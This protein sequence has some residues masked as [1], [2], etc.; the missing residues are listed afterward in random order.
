MKKKQ[1]ITKDTITEGF[2]ISLALV[3]FIPVFFFLFTILL[4]S[5]KTYFNYFI[6]TGNIICFVSGI[7]KVIWKLIV[8]LKKKNVWWMFQQ[9]RI[10]LPIGF[11]LIM[12]GLIFGWKHFSN[13]FYNASFY[14]R[15]FFTLWIIGMSLMSFFAV[16]LDPADPKANWIEQITNSIAQ[17]FLCLA[18]YFL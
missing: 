9:M 3:D 5:M 1:K 14:S 6:M 12:M 7:I 18:A 17:S 2:T 4:F 8:V 11:T 15:I 13:T 16:K 10:G